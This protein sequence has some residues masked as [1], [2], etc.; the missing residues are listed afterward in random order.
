MMAKIPPVK[1]LPVKS[2]VVEADLLDSPLGRKL[3]PC[4]EDISSLPRIP[5]TDY[6]N[7][8]RNSLVLT[9]HFGSFIK[10]CPGT[11]GYNCCGLG[12][13]HFGLGCTID[14]SYCILRGYLDT[15]ALVLFGNL[16]E[17]LADLESMLAAPEPPHKRFCTGEFTDS[18]LLEDLTGLGGRLIDL[19]SGARDR[20]LELKTK[21]VNIRGLLDHDHNGRTAISFSVNAPGVSELEEPRAPS[22]AKRIEAA[23]QA[24]RAGYRVGFHFDPIILHPGWKDGYRDTL[25]RIFAVVPPERVI[26]ISMGAFR[27][28]PPLKDIVRKR[29]PRS[30]IFDPEFIL[31]GDGKMRY[32]RPVRVE[33]Y[34]FMLEEIRQRAP[35]TCV[36][37]CMES[38]RV[39]R[40]VYGF[41]PGTDGLI[42][43]LDE[44]I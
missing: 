23:E 30:N 43:M 22:L 24:V 13:I 17:G 18:L 29:F 36:Y 28:L 4:F 6:G 3:K 26:W 34:R 11:R 15:E 21:T 41:D 39:W 5:P 25:D 42:R 37:M 9:R 38:S 44:R 8:G 7:H 19:F 40:E 27:Y 20:L 2:L 32:L 31:A 16:E 1:R 14:C 12:I 35:Q 10:P 33:I